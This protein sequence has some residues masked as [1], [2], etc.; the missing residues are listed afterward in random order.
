M[1]V[2]R[3]MSMARSMAADLL[4]PRWRRGDSAICSPTRITGFRADIGS[5]KIIAISRPARRRR[6]LA[7]MPC[8]SW[9]RYWTDPDSTLTPA[10]SRFAIARSV[11]DLPEPDSPTMPK[12]SPSATS[13][14]MSSTMRV[15][16]LPLRCTPRDR[17]RTES[18]GASVISLPPVRAEQV[19]QPVAE[20]GKPQAGD[21]DREAGNGRLLPLRGDELLAARDHRSP[22]GGGRGDAKPQ[23]AKRDD[24]HD[25]LHDV[26]H[27]V[28]DRL[29]E[30]VRADVAG[31][32]PH[33]REAAEPRGHDVVL[34]LGDED[35]AADDLGVGH[36]RHRRDRQVDARLAGPEDEDQDDDHHVERE[37]EEEVAQAHHDQVDPA[38]EVAGQA[39][40]DR[41]DDERDQHRDEADAQV[42]AR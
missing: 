32:H 24:G 22:F 35:L 29:R 23:V 17:L 2:L 27:R 10:G 36:P 11:R 39:A 14:L 37:R 8:R 1:P 30:D 31:K 38:A 5:W 18:S 40:Q 16:G 6:N 34:L 33:V 15:V 20:P 42:D 28:D 7:G 9:P 19:G 26:A 21:D 25:V 41:P 4:S 3:I 12:R 13:K